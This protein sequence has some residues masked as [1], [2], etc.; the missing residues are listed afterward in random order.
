MPDAIAYFALRLILGMALM[1]CLMP[2]RQ[3]A[4]AFFRI[5]MLLL[6]GLAVV[7][8]LAGT[9]SSTMAVLL[10]LAAFMGS[11]FWTLE[12]RQSGT[13]ALGLVLALALAA[14]GQVLLQQNVSGRSGWLAAAS[15]LASAGTLGAAMTGMLLGH[16]YLTAPGMPLEPL[17]RMNNLLGVSALARLALSA[18]ALPMAWPDAGNATLITWLALRWLAGIA[19]PLAVW[20]LVRKILL[21][22]NTQ[23]A[24]GVLFVGVILVFIGELSADLASQTLRVAL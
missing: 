5:M 15:A 18:V 4:S 8:A 21:Y 17:A 1:L 22:R 16:R 20:F 11:V 14:A 6:M 13:V 3:V 9:G 10:A 2:R 24:T 7:M 12:R 19:G 23:S